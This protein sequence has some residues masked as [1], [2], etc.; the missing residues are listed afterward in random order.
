MRRHHVQ[1]E[2]ELREK[3]ILLRQQFLL[4]AGNK[5]RVWDLL[6]HS[7]SSFATLFRHALI[8]LGQAAPAEKREAVQ[9][10]SK[11]VRFDPSA[12]DQVLDVRERKAGPGKTDIQDLFARY[13]AAI[14]QVTAAVDQVLDAEA[15][16]R[17]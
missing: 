11:V 17:S 13:M 8:A 16:S 10:L 15:A 3:L 5:R 12:I 4:V 7:V 2:Y 9:A 1:V 6:L 14:E